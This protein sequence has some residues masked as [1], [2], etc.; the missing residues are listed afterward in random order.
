MNKDFLENRK[1]MILVLNE[2]RYDTRVKMQGK[3]LSQNGASVLTVALHGEGL[4]VNE[5]N[6]RNQLIRIPLRT[7]KWSQNRFI[8]LFKW[9]E[10]LFHVLGITVK[11]RPDIVHSNDW[12]TLL[13]G[14]I[15]AKL[16]SKMLIYDSHEYWYECADS[17]TYPKLIR[18]LQRWIEHAFGKR[19]N[20]IVT[21]SQSVLKAILQKI[22]NTCGMVVHNSWLTKIPERKL[23]SRGYNGNQ[24]LKIL[25]LG[26]ISPG[27]GIETLVQ[28]VAAT[29]GVLLDI[30]GYSVHPM[31]K[32]GDILKIIESSYN[33]H[34]FPPIKAEDIYSIA[35]KYDIGVIPHSP[36]PKSRNLALPNKL[37]EYAGA[38]LAILS[39]KTIGLFELIDPYQAGVFFEAENS[40]NLN[41][42][43]KNI[44]ENPEIIANWQTGALKIAQ[45]YNEETAR[46]ELLKVYSYVCRQL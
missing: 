26:V 33:I 32:I 42:T 44:V 40:E 13:A 31:N 25:Y 29:S 3:T 46:M 9:I 36:Y 39:S 22:P 34:L 2:M 5:G 12:N 1:V 37:F 20:V 16:R 30:Y 21:V 10:F 18:K 23:E 28:S 27:K 4:L 35:Q 7:R 43:L 24:P 15:A 41:N 38:G 14:W 8:Q 19:A 6:D 11:F 17:I 45:R